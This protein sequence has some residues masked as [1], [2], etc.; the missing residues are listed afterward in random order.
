MPCTCMA[1]TPRIMRGL[2]DYLM[3]DDQPFPCRINLGGFGQDS[4][5]ALQSLDFQLDHG[6]GHPQV[7]DIDGPHRHG[8]ELDKIL[9]R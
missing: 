8:P 2:A 6:R 7:V 9:R 4:E 1:A 5:E 3:L